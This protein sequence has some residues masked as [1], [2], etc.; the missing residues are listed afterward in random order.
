MK[1]VVLTESADRWEP[2]HT[3]PSMEKEI[4]HE[5]PPPSW[6]TI[7]SRFL[8]EEAESVF[9]KNID[10]V[11]WPGSHGRTHIQEYLGS[12][13]CWEESDVF[14]EQEEKWIGI[15]R[16]LAG[17]DDHYTRVVL[18]TKLTRGGI[19]HD[20]IRTL[21]YDQDLP[22]SRRYL[23]YSDWSFSWLIMCGFSNI[24]I[25]FLSKS[26]LALPEYCSFHS[27]VSIFKRPC[28]STA[29]KGSPFFHQLF[30][31]LR[32]CETGY[33]YLKPTFTFISIFVHYSLPLTFKLHKII[34]CI[35]HVPL[36]VWIT[37]SRP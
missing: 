4:R 7:G 28:L 35:P 34:C 26:H 11:C 5:V 31:P 33:H 8:L 36:L 12:A 2:I 32:H 1:P 10:P 9:S 6:G 13:Q 14:D 29:S 3:K 22:V 30:V 21:H 37:C 16:K 18:M 15:G 24:S 20:D 25:Q 19:V 23:L 27:S 17:L